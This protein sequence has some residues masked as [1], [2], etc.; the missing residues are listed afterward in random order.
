MISSDLASRLCLAGQQL[1]SGAIP[2]E[3][4][5]PM[6]RQ[7]SWE[8]TLLSKHPLPFKPAETLRAAVSL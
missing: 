4:A 7:F 6:E 8:L 2:W 5:A 1:K 3:N